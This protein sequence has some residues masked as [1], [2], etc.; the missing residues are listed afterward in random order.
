[1]ENI[2]IFVTILAFFKKGMEMKMLKKHLI[3]VLIFCAV[4]GNFSDANAREFDENSNLSLGIY[5]DFGSSLGVGAEFGFALYSAPRW[6]LINIIS[7]ETK[8]LKLQAT[9]YDTLALIF[10]EKLMAG[11]LFGSSVASHIGFSY[12]RPYL[13]LSGGFGLIHTDGVKMG[14]EPYYY[15]VAAGL[16]HEF[17]T[18]NGHTL[19]FEFSGGIGNLTHPLPLQIKQATLGGLFKFALG[20]R[21][22]F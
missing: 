20:Y 8:G 21:W 10:H 4:C 6:Q 18:E 11:L 3:F 22:Y 15:E 7:V 12:F 17:I 2:Q 19:Y 1:M 14:R 13:F 5:G 16:G 9:R